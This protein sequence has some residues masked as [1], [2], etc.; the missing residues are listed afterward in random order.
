VTALRW[1][2]LFGAGIAAANLVLQFIVTPF[3]PW[4]L[5]GILSAGTWFAGVAAAGSLAGARS[6]RVGATAAAIAAGVDLARN[7]AVLIAVGVPAVQ[8][9]A[10]QG[11]P[12]PGLIVAGA[13]M[14]FFLLSPIAA[15]I[16]LAAARASR[17]SPGP[18]AVAGH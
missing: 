17:R 8:S 3:A 15:G 16:G 2:L 11:S 9:S 14:E 7:A 13:I 12:T 1:G 4:Q 5:V 10:V 18:Q 6:L